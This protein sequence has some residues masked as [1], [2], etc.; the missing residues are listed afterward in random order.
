M[1]TAEIFPSVDLELTCGLVV[2]AV[3]PFQAENVPQKELIQ[4]TQ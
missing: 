1:S 3:S 2:V 4:R